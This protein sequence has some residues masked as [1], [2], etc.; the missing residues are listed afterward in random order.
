MVK[1]KSV[2][3]IVEETVEY[4]KTHPRGL[5]TQGGGCVYFNS[6]DNSK[7][8]AVGRCMN[9]RAPFVKEL[10]QKEQFLAVE[11]VDTRVKGLDN[12]LRPQYRG[13]STR[14]W[15]RL[16]SLHDGTAYWNE[17]GQLMKEGEK[18]HKL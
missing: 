15:K 7:M 4:Y 18:R 13:H 3:E 6:E 12:V 5:A 10:M 14:F 2:K 8:C 1:Q 17:D 16:Q 11:S 9:T